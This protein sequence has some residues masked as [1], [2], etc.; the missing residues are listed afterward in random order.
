MKTRIQIRFNLTVD[1]DKSVEELVQAG[2]YD[3][4]DRD[5]SSKNFTAQGRGTAQL[6]AVLV[7]LNRYAESDEVL[8]EL[9]KGRL[10]AGTLAELLALGAQHPAAQRENPI[11]AL[12]LVWCD[13]YGSRYVPVLDSGGSGRG[14]NLYWFGGGWD[15]SYRFLAFRE[16][17]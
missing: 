13:P 12:G 9:A 2:K 1:Y 16:E 5:I 11:V 10:C 4:S 8:A 7:H 15:H 17:S 14:L 3:R 6:E